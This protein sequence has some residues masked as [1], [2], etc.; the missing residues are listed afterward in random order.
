MERVSISLTESERAELERLVR[1]RNTQQK[2][3][4]R[5]RIVILT[6]DGVATG[7]I[8]GRLK[9]TCPTITRWRRRY[10]EQGL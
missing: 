5:A 7:E 3:V 10:G 2:V 8:M 6:A 4:L 9:T 1:G